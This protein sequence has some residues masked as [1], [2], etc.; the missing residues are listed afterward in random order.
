MTHSLT[1]SPAESGAVTL[2]SGCTISA[3]TYAMMRTERTY[4][5]FLDTRM[6][7]AADL[8]WLLADLSRAPVVLP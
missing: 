5:G 3:S 2:P 8:Q 6:Y 4:H 1:E 7:T